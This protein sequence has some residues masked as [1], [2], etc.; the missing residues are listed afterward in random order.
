MT[1][2]CEKHNLDY[3]EVINDILGDIS[4]CPMCAEEAEKQFAEKE[5]EERKELIDAATIASYK[6]MGIKPIYYDAT[7][8]NF[9]ADTPELKLNLEAVKELVVKQSGTIVMTGNYG[10]GKTHLECAAVKELKGKYIK[11]FA[12]SERIRASYVDTSRGTSL[13][14]LDELASVPI[15]A[16]D[17]MGRSKGSD[18]ELNYLSYVFDERHASRLP[19]IFASNRHMVENCPSHG[20]DNCLQNF[21]GDDMMSRICED[22]KLLNFSGRDFR[23][24]GR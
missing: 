18:W 13:D 23:L 2:H 16:I 14:I 17:E 1:R 19:T 8:D 3:E 22:G 7:F 10:A 21:F 24:E 6:A 4:S 11:M 12:I 15:L 5:V 9:I 20:C